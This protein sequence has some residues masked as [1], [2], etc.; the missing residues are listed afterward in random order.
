MSELA[1]SKL[2]KIILAIVVVGVVVVGLFLFFK[3]HIND[4][5]KNL[6]GGNETNLFLSLVK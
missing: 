2:I 1:I 3:D 6:A 4:F 5:F